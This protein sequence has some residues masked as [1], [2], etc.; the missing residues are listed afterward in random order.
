MH[1]I[2]EQPWFDDGADRKGSTFGE[3]GRTTIWQGKSVT[4]AFF[5][6]V[7]KV[8]WWKC[9]GS[10]VPQTVHVQLQSEGSHRNSYGYALWDIGRAARPRRPTDGLDGLG[11]RDAQSPVWVTSG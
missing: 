6:A 9:E 1:R 11:A 2:H 7:D 3:V 10:S 4:V 5:S 8:R